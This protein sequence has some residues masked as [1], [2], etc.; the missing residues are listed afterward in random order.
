[1]SFSL[2]PDVGRRVLGLIGH[3]PLLTSDDGDGAQDAHYHEARKEQLRRGPRQALLRGRRYWCRK[4]RRGHRRGLRGH[5]PV[6]VR[7]HAEVVFVHP[8]AEPTTLA[9]V[10]TPR[11]PA[12]PELDSV[13]PAPAGNR[14]LLVQRHVLAGFVVDATR[15]GPEALG[16]VKAAADGAALVD[17]GLHRV[18]AAHR[19]ILRDEPHDGLLHTHAGAR[20]D[21]PLLAAGRAVAADVL[22]L[23]GVLLRLVVLARL[24]RDTAPMDVGVGAGGVAARAGA[25]G[26]AVEQHLGG[27]AD[28]GPNPAPHN[29]NAVAKRSGD[30]L[31]PATRA[32]A[33][34][35]VL[36]LVPGHIAPAGDVAPI[37]SARQT[38]LAQ[39]LVGPGAGHELATDCIPVQA[40][41]PASRRLLGDV[42]F[43]LSEKSLHRLGGLLVVLRVP[44]LLFLEF[45]GLHGL[46]INM[47]PIG[48]PIVGRRCPIAAGFDHDVVRATSNTRP[49]VE[50]PIG[51]PRIAQDPIIL[52]VLC[53]VADH[54]DDV[55]DGFRVRLVLVDV[56]ADEIHEFWWGG[57]GAGDGAPLEL[58]HHVVLALNYAILSDVVDLIVRR[59]L[60][61][62]LVAHPANVLRFALSAGVVA[63]R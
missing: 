32:L 37:P 46:H 28:L 36:V 12:V 29:A 34:G 8:D 23:A 2:D 30:S 44:P 10:G 61:T 41:N 52:S 5:A 57:D 39:L 1:M 31:G 47:P 16:G 33:V 6:A 15:V 53:A 59:S 35:Q 20:P 60:A 26:A 27:E 9:P 19:A 51:A 24:V 55:V 54:A 11:V 58:R 38:L 49:A 14:D 18:D 13:L 56:P 22:V 45:L 4:H 50:A 17:L 3:R 7:L 21:E 25:A 43:G 62:F 42:V 48:L 40:R 63:R